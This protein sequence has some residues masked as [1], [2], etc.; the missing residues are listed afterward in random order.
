[1]TQQSCLNTLAREKFIEA[2]G[3]PHKELDQASAW[4]VRLAASESLI[5]VL[6]DNYH[7]QPAVWVF[8]LVESGAGNASHRLIQDEHAITSVVAALKQVVRP[9]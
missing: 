1:M 4:S 3:E 5:H 9:G 7:V 6:L 8:G 2:F